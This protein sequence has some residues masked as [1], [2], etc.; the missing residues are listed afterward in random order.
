MANNTLRIAGKTT[1]IAVTA[2]SSTSVTVTPTTPDNV[3]FASFLNVGTK[4]CAVNISSL[5]TAPAAVFPAAGTPGNYVLPAN[6][7]VPIV[8]AVPQTSFSV[9]AICGGTD[10]TT[11]LVTPVENQ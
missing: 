8:L 2:T 3:S 4:A 9:T 1:F 5:A 10:T 7:I 6:M 11:L